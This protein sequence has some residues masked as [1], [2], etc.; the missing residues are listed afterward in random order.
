MS[1]PGVR[2]A[3][4]AMMGGS[5]TEQQAA[6]A[7]LRRL[8]AARSAAA[9]M[10]KKVADANMAERKDTAQNKLADLL[11]PTDPMTQAILGAL[12]G[13]MNSAASANATTQE[14]GFQGQLIDQFNKDPESVT[15]ELAN[16]Y[17]AIAGRGAMM[18]GANVNP[19]E[20]QADKH[21][22]QKALTDA[23]RSRGDASERS[24]RNS[25]LG[26][27]NL[28]DAEA[29]TL[30]GDGKDPQRGTYGDFLKWQSKKKA[31]HPNMFQKGGIDLSVG[32]YFIEKDTV[33]GA[34]EV[35]KG[36]TENPAKVSDGLTPATAIDPST[37]DEAPAP[38]T[39]LMVDG[40]PQKYLGSKAK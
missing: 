22:Y 5:A 26:T 1:F 12:A 34:Q 30:F 38:G 27:V 6:D 2:S 8:T 36:A 15:P 3:I 24:N 39:W 25:P 9:A 37:L 21:A 23:A 11:D 13:Q 31:D 33:A 29:Y 17:Q 28:T 14:T 35:V 10:D 4:Q 16:L 19:T 20:D 7:E 32:A 40:K 18:T